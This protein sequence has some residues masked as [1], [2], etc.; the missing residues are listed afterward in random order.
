VVGQRPSI[1]S[2]IRFAA[3]IA[4][5][6]A[7]SVAGHGL[8]S[9]CASLRAA[10]IEAAISSAYLRPSSTSPFYQTICFFFAPCYFGLSRQPTGYGAGQTDERKGKM[11]RER[12]GRGILEGVGWPVLTVVSYD[13]DDATKAK[14][15]RG[16]RVIAK[17]P[18]GSFA[19][20]LDINKWETIA[21]E[22]DRQQIQS[23]FEQTDRAT[24][25]GN[26]EVFQNQTT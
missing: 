21:D 20:R 17:L 2:K 5:A 9:Y 10:R 13:E 16:S 18:D 4:S 6:I 23:L 15:I 3:E 26:S 24:A 8:Y 19:N 1:L 25:N 14:T 12:Y 7:H 11:R 22:A